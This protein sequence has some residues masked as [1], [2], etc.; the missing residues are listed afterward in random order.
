MVYKEKLV[1]KGPYVYEL[2]REGTMLVPGRIF[3][4]ELLMKNIEEKSIEQVRNVAMLPGIVKYS[5][6][7]PDV[8]QGYGFPIGGVAA[9][10]VEKGVISPG[11][12]GYDISCSV[13]TLRTNLTL[14]D[15]EKKKMEIVNALFHAVPS[16]VGKGTKIKITKKDMID[17]LNKGAEWAVEK[18]YGKKEDIERTEEGGR[19]KD[20][21]AAEVSE[22]AIE[23]GLGQLGSLGSG[24]HFLEMQYVEKIFSGDIAKIFGLQEG[25]ITFMIHCG[26]RGLGHQVASDYIKL[27]EE[28]YGYQH[29]PDRELVYAPIHSELGKKYWKAMNAAANFAFCNKQVITHLVREAM[30]KIFP[31]FEAGVV[32]DI[33]HNIAKMEEYIIDGKK[34]KVCTHRKGATRSYGPGRKELPEVYMKIGQPINIPGSMGTASY[35]LV[36]TKEAEELSFNSTAHGAGRNKSRSAALR[37]WRGEKIRDELAE[38]GIIVRAGSVKGI[39]E[40]APGAYKDVDEVVRVS[41]DAGIGSAVARLVPLAVVKG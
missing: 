32:Y 1:K 30:R 25:Q 13:R 27:M 10:D 4:S 35:I 16:G 26:S 28:E 2:P 6:A 9:F 21:D 19:M 33:C 31:S 38:R 17:I 3:A 5:I 14:K 11:G 20:A 7:M 37:E 12:V 29:L 22:K 39:A 34:V 40:E 36:G 15:V 8:H 24:N 18:G 23:R 41:T